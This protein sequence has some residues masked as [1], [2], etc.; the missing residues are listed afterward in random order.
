MSRP[1]DNAV[2]PQAGRCTAK[3]TVGDELGPAGDKLELLED[4][5]FKRALREAVCSFKVHA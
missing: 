5:G 2:M 3:R 1:D 4:V